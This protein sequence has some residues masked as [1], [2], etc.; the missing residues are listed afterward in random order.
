MSE[1]TQTTTIGDGKAQTSMVDMGD[2]YVIAMDIEAVKSMLEILLEEFFERFD[3]EKDNPDVA[4]CGFL[5]T[6]SFAHAATRLLEMT[7]ADFEKQGIPTENE[8]IPQEEDGE[9]GTG[10]HRMKDLYHIAMDIKTIRD[11]FE[12]TLLERFY[13]GIDLAE[14]EAATAKICQRFQKMKSVVR[15]MQMV[16]YLDVEWMKAQGLEL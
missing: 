3:P 1:K 12:R 16:S 13:F 4:L 10:N 7:L 11:L 14:H 5:Y 8:K 15:A 6:R 2:F 9:S